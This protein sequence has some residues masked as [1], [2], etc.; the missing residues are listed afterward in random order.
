MGEGSQAS[1]PAPQLVFFT[2]AGTFQV[3][4]KTQ[5]ISRFIR[6]QAHRRTE[7]PVAMDSYSKATAPHLKP[8]MLTNILFSC[9]DLI[10]NG[11]IALFMQ[12]G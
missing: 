2:P 7:R 11:K 9:T 4:G 3:P 5:S 12:L 10:R 8:H 6:S 1:Y